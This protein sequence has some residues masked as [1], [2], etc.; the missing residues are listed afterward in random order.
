MSEFKAWPKIPRWENSRW[1][2]TEKIDGTNACVVI[3]AL[4]NVSAQSR[5][6]IITLQDD[7]FGFAEWVNTHK[8]E[9]LSLGE[10]HHYGEWWG[11]GI[12]RGYGQSEKIFSLFDFWREGDSLP[13]C[14]RTVPVLGKTI[15]GALANLRQNGSRA[16]PGWDRP[17]GLVLTNSD[18]RQQKVMYKY[19][20]DK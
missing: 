9:L 18:Y 5:N 19:I 7:N 8:E 14:C 6:R 16:A 20:L 13:S 10:G 15:E 4:G 3:D 12:Q 1:V 11:L 2:V 17:E